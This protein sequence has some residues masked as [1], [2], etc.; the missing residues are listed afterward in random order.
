MIF[1][2]IHTHLPENCIID[3]PEEIK[4]FRAALSEEEAIKNGCRLISVYVS[5]T[6]H[7]DYIIF[8]TKEHENMLSFLKPLIKL[9][10]TEVKPVDEWKKVSNYL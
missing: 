10:I 1:L 5:P 2:A 6:E 4:K 3:N 8:E 7:V 9:G